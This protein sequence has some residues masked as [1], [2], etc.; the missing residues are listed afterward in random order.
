MEKYDEADI[1]KLI[2]DCEILILTEDAEVREIELS[3]LQ[4]PT[5][6]QEVQQEKLSE[7]RDDD[8]EEFEAIFQHSKAKKDQT[9]V[10]LMTV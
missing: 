7:S 5:T 8:E 2:N 4:L 1:T 3:E 10:S 6:S 9:K